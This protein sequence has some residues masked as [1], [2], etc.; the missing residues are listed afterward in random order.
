MKP[1]F[2]GNLDE[3]CIQ[4]DDRHIKII[5]A[6]KKKKHEKNMEDS[7]FSITIIRIGMS[8][9][10]TGPWVFLLKGKT[11]PSKLLKDIV[12]EFN[13]PPGSFVHMTKNAN[14]SDSVWDEIVPKICRGIREMPVV[15][16]HPDWWVGLSMDGYGSHVNTPK[17]LCEFAK[18]KICV[19]KEEG[20]TL[21]TSIKLMINCLSQEVCQAS[22]GYS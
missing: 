8:S 15:K 12:A 9:G 3:T 2:F 14:L 7:Q 13:V 4:V 10:E 17:A 5:G 22:S 16:D 1:S 18:H 11:L 6:A 19:V 21:R 20:V